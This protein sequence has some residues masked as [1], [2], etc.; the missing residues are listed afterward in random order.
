VTNSRRAIE[1]AEDF[2]GLKLRV[3]QNPE[4]TNCQRRTTR[5]FSVMEGSH[6]V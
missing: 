2:A 6:G 5:A 1:K 3:I 4:G